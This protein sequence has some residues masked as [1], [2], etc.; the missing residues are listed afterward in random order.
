MRDETILKRDNGDKVKILCEVYVDFHNP[1]NWQINVH[2]QQKGKRLWL[3]THST[4]DYA[5][6]R[7]DSKERERY[8]M[9]IY[10]KYVSAEE[11]YQAKL[12]L[13]EQMKP[14]P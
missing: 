10:L 12:S 14:Q 7:L 3:G 2:T 4:D 9:T 5:W 11:I 8:E 13:W 6:R 1:P